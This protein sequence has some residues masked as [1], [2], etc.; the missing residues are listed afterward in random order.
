MKKTV[1]LFALILCAITLFSACAGQGTPESTTDTKAEEVTTG[2]QEPV[3]VAFRLTEKGKSVVSVIRPDEASDAIVQTAMNV[4]TKVQNALGGLNVAIG[5]D[6]I[7]PG[8]KHDAKTYEI[9]IGKT[10]YD[11]TAEALS[12]MRYSDYGIRVIGNK[13]VVTAPNDSR[14]NYAVNKLNTLLSKNV[15]KDEN[16]DYWLE[17]TDDVFRA[18][19]KVNK[20]TINGN[21]YENYK[22]V[23]A[24]NSQYQSAA[25]AVSETLATATGIQLPVITDNEAESEFEILVGNSK[26]ISLESKIAEYDIYMVGNKLVFNCLGENSSSAG[27]KKLY[28]EKLAVGGD[29]N[30]TPD[31]KIKGYWNT[32]K[33]EPLTEGADLRIISWNILT[34]E[35]GGTETAPRA[36]IFGSV[37]EK[38]K[39][40][41]VGIQEVCPIWKK[42]IKVYAPGYTEICTA[43][44][45]G[46]VNYSSIIYDNSKYEVVTSGVIPYSM[47]ANKKCRNM[48][49]AILKSKTSDFKFGLISTH[50]DFDNTDANRENY[51][52]V[53]AAELAAKVA[54]LEKQYECPVFT[55]GD[56]NCRQ[57]STSMEYFRSINNMWC[58][59][60]DAKVKLNNYGSASSL[61]QPSYANGNSID[62]VFATKESTEILAMMTIIN[63]NTQDVSDHRPILADIKIKK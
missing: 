21:P 30:L 26:R 28:S 38:Y 54:E 13:L 45:D 1:K 29:I 59:Y 46:T 43:C 23:Y 40:D 52:R 62:F 24:R 27:T 18:T 19:Y 49:W 10:N 4:R 7:I 32:D 37:L 56:Y 58:S 15:T 63:C 8:K 16:G 5:N 33:G 9:L 34:E 35:W 6:F 57:D 41:A 48:G 25:E 36:E 39:P 50:W 61:G 20:L 42:A 51:R 22:I 60:F 3:K 12:D 44:P 17:V 53:Q 31:L 55:T 47:T 11:E 2:E 14:L